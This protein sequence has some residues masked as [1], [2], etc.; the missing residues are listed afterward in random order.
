MC[1]CIGTLCWDEFQSSPN[2]LEFET[3]SLVDVLEVSHAQHRCACS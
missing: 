3:D 1:R 2:R